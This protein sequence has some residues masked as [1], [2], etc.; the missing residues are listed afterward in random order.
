MEQFWIV[1]KDHGEIQK[2]VESLG[3]KPAII[4]DIEVTGDKPGLRIDF[5]GNKDEG[6]LSEGRETTSDVTWQRFFE[7]M[8][9]RNLAFMYSNE[10][11]PRNPSM[12]YRFVN[13]ETPFE[14]TI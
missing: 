6:L 12:A 7:L 5:P 8:E 14:N 3:G 9:S 2:W 1:A 10:E 13:R 4:D 11:K